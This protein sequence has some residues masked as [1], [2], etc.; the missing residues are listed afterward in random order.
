MRV[1]EARVEALETKVTDGVAALGA[2]TGKAEG[3]QVAYTT[4]SKEKDA[5]LDSCSTLK[6]QWA[7]VRMRMCV[8]IAVVRVRVCACCIG[9]SQCVA[10]WVA[11]VCVRV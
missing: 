3:L 7:M 11:M 6:A 4:V 5:L 1:L 2:A 8:C 9:I 10:V